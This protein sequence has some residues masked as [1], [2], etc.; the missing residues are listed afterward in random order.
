M[1]SHYLEIIRFLRIGYVMQERSQWRVQG[2]H[3]RRELD[4]TRF[5]TGFGSNEHR[6]SIAGECALSGNI[7]DR[8]S[9]FVTG[10]KRLPTR[11]T[12]HPNRK[13][14]ATIIDDDGICTTKQ[15]QYRTSVLG[16]IV[17]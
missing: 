10:L 8:T 12:Q 6:P 7:N 15:W 17:T 16:I 3:G 9:F 14:S 13:V 4:K 2:S 11:N 5:Y 1:F